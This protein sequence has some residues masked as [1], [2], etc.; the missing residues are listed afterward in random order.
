M[1]LELLKTK[2]ATVPELD[3]DKGISNS[4]GSLKNYRK[5]LYLVFKSIRFKLPMLS[6]MLEYDEYDGLRIILH[7]MSQ[8]LTTVGA[9]SL[10]EA[11]RSIEKSYLNDQLTADVFQIYLEHLASFVERLE[12]GIRQVDSLLQN[13]PD[14]IHS[15]SNYKETKS[16]YDMA[17]IDTISMKKVM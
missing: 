1:D 16:S 17:S 3:V 8:F 6:S 9:D 7:T 5:S 2:L 13:A 4:V 12:T 11:S 14:H 15:V 10:V